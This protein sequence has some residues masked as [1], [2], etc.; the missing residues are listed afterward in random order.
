[1]RDKEPSLAIAMVSQKDL[2]ATTRGCL[3]LPSDD[4]F[5]AAKKTISKALLLH[6][7][8]VLAQAD[9]TFQMRKGPKFSADRARQVPGFYLNPAEPRTVPGSGAFWVRTWRVRAAG[10][11][12][13]KLALNEGLA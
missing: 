10:S 12:I 8:L 1:M 9:C 4:W 5:V 11:S 7:M 13:F 6:L 3:N 2:H